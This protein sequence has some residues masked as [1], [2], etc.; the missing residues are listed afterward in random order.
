[1]ISSVPREYRAFGNSTAQFFL[2]LLGF[3][4]SPF[5]YGLICKMTGGRSSPWGMA[6]LMVWSIFGLGNIFMAFAL[7]KRKRQTDKKENFESETGKEKL[8]SISESSESLNEKKKKTNEITDT[9][10]NVEFIKTN[11]EDS[12]YIL[13]KKSSL[14]Q[15]SYINS[16]IVP[17]SIP[18]VKF[19]KK[20]KEKSLSISYEEAREKL[21]NRRILT[22]QTF[23]ET[24]KMENLT[25][26]FRLR[27]NSESI[28]HEPEILD[29]RGTEKF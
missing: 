9:N 4:P 16:I 29:V 8:S 26:T 20:K 23:I 15:I 14:I 25:K 27:N 21:N 19:S 5:I 11:K 17:L 24:N 3:L 2:N 18:K 1:M 13:K 7:D 6:S 12:K 10:E 22:S 28:N